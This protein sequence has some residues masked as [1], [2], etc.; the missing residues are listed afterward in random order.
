M[1]KRTRD[2][3][4]LLFG[5]LANPTRLRIVELL[6]GGERTV[7]DVAAA[8]NLPQPSTSQHLAVLAR[9]GV[10]AVEPRGASRIYRVRG[11]RIVRILALIEEFCAIHSLYGP[12][13]DLGIET[14]AEKSEPTL[15]GTHRSGLTKSFQQ[16]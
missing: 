16:D 7:N 4:S 9:A 13:D 10:L 3:A 5:A 15:A 14:E 1:D 12:E 8:L 11:P 6:C 2:R